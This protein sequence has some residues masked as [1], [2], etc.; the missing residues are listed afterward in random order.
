MPFIVKVDL[1]E[2]KVNGNNE[3]GR[4][5]YLFTLSS[6]DRILKVRRNVPHKGPYP[7]TF[8]VKQN[9]LNVFFENEV[10]LKIIMQVEEIDPIFSETTRQELE[11]SNILC[12]NPLTMNVFRRVTDP[13]ARIDATFHFI[14]SIEPLENQIRFRQLLGIVKRLLIIKD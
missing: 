13:R 8:E 12:S 9:L 3:I 10:N 6:F 4:D 7:Y 2:I 1:Q 5:E 14:I 11:I